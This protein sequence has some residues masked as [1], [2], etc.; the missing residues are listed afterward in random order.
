M[1]PGSSPQK[2]SSPDTSEISSGLSVSDK[3]TWGL[4]YVCCWPPNLIYTLAIRQLC[5]EVHRF[6]L[7]W[8]RCGGSRPHPPHTR[9]RPAAW[10]QRT[11]SRGKAGNSPVHE[12]HATIW[13]G[14][15]KVNVEVTLFTLVSL[16]PP[17]F[18][19]LVLVFCCFQTL[20]SFDRLP[21]LAQGQASFLCT[22][23]FSFYFQ[24]SLK[25]P[26]DRRMSDLF[27]VE[28]QSGP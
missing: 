24:S 12:G 23:R 18:L 16:P 26:T 5:P 10:A 15:K 11:G 4:F 21:V 9:W 8:C 20:P 19:F 28:F 27:S 2:K 17:P 1:C 13:G 14:K 6:L 3:H 22:N 7:C 25:M